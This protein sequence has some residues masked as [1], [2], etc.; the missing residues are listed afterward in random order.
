MTG[1]P[2]EFA[3]PM[4]YFP[5][6]RKNKRENK[7]RVCKN[8]D[9]EKITSSEYRAFNSLSENVLMDVKIS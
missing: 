6:F 7:K 9:P 4:Q 3:V 1:P 5:F 8:V 2:I